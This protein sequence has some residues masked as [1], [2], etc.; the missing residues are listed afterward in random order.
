MDMDNCQRLS[1]EQQAQWVAKLHEAEFHEPDLSSDLL[2]AGL[3]IAYA[4]LALVWLRMVAQRRTLRWLF[5]VRRRVVAPMVV[6]YAVW[7]AQRV[8]EQR[9]R[10][11]TF[12]EPATARI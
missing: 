4:V 12:T 1:P 8:K 9:P 11:P 2:G 7:S 3:W 5:V 10:V 6:R